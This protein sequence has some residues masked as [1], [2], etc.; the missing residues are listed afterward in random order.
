MG[1]RFRIHPTTPQQRFIKRAVDVL[2]NRGVVIIPTDTTYAFATLPGSKSAVEKVSRIKSID[3]RKK[4]FSLIVPDLADIAR[5]ALVTNHSYRIL[6][7]FLPGP[8][9]FVLPASR[10]V[11]RILE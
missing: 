5:Y 10:E 1:A 4:L 9:T 3:A 6:R 2:H 11:P 7:R 8:Y